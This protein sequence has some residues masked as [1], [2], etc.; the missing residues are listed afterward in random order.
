MHA[1]TQKPST[2][3]TRQVYVSVLDKKGAP[4][5]T[6][7]PTD[8]NVREDG[9]PRE[10]IEV[11][12]ADQPMHL[13]LLVDDSQAAS[14]AT[15]HLREGLA[16]LLERL[17]GQATIALITFGERPTVVADYTKD[18]EQL[19][20]RAARLFPRQG[21]GAYLLDAIFDASR[22]LARRETD[23]PV[24]LAITFEGVEYSNR[25]YQPVL[26]ELMKS[27]ATLHV[28]AV[29]T[30]S[31]SL[32]D[33]MR[34][35]NMVIAEGTV[36]TGGRRDQVLAVSGIPDKLKQVAD[37][38]LHQHV[39]TY[40]RPEALIPPEK[41]EVTTTRRDWTVRARTRLVKR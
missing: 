14:D 26:D 25:H 37:E 5:E 31:S 3:R 15:S 39:L 1:Q 9:K 2:E 33:E 11:R 29:G 41:L 6:V 27:G 19:K 12:P 32:D 36:R 7:A 22:G 8:F 34:N 23:R 21:A 10:V 28:V 40:G 38:M 35:R 13:A 30:P 4:V 16:A 18:T 20:A 17:Q 24:I